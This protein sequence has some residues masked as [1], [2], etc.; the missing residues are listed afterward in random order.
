[1]QSKLWSVALFM[2]LLSAAPADAEIIKGMMVI[3]GAEM[4]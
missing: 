3:K 1:M 4:S 2:A